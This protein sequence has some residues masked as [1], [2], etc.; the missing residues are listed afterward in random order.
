MRR[1]AEAL[2]AQ[3]LEEKFADAEAPLREGFHALRE[4]LN[5][6]P[7]AVRP[8]TIGLAREWIERLYQGWGQPERAAALLQVP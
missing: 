6:I 8:N 7:L 5:A 3:W 2:R 1:R 4:S